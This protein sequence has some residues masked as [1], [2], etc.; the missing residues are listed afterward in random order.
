MIFCNLAV[1]VKRAPII[2]K[3]ILSPGLEW[4]KF[5]INATV[6][7]RFDQKYQPLPVIFLPYFSPI[8]EVESINKT[9]NMMEVTWLCAF[10]SIF[11]LLPLTLHIVGVYLLRTSSSYAQNQCGYLIQVSLDTRLECFFKGCDIFTKKF[12]GSEDNPKNIFPS[13]KNKGCNFF[14]C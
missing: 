7:L 5:F 3:A 6:I 10:Q 4:I 11:S 9:S 14:Q 2:W 12:K 1:S 8:L 13:E